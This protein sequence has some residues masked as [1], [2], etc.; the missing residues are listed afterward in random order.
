MLRHRDERD[1][2]TSRLPLGLP[3][4]MTGKFVLTHN[5]RPNLTPDPVYPSS[6][7]SSR[8][9]SDRKSAPH[10]LRKSKRL[11]GFVLNPTEGA[12]AIDGYIHTTH[13]IFSRLASSSICCKKVLSTRWLLFC[14]SADGLLSTSS[15]SQ[16][17]ERKHGSSARRDCVRS[18]GFS[19]ASL[20]NLD[21]ARRFAQSRLLHPL[22]GPG[23]HRRALPGSASTPA[24][25]RYRGC[26]NNRCCE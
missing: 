9:C 22:P 5:Q 13:Y 18:Q 7:G 2:V 14:Y 23:L 10:S 20:L 24:C 1:H 8:D 19:K 11:K 17:R 26:E 16:Q 4:P 21:F 15:S 6:G 25:V 12:F 3:R